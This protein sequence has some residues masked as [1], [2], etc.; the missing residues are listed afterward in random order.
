MQ[1]A[2]II[3]GYSLGGADILRRAMGR[4]RRYGNGTAV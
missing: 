2:Q 1:V 4:E 3:A